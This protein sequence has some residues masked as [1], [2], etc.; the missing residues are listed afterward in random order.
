MG[1]VTYGMG[2]IGYVPYAGSAHGMGVCA[3]AR[4]AV[5]CRWHGDMRVSADGMGVSKRPMAWGPR[6]TPFPP[7]YHQP[8]IGA[9]TKSPK[10][11]LDPYRPS[12]GGGA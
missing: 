5:K 4:G 7:A 6:G 11:I 9:K 3:I 10:K 8:K 2:A 12:S 1:Y